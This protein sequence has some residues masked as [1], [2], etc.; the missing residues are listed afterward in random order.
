MM[1][2]A[3]AVTNGPAREPVRP[4]AQPPKPAVL[5][6]ETAQAEEAK[7]NAEAEPAQ[8]HAALAEVNQTMQMASIGVRF[9]FDKEADTMIAKVVDVETGVVIRQM[10]SAEVVRIA[11]VLGKLQ[12]LLVSQQV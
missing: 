2:P 1:I 6:Q 9:E 7:K 5:V 11:K 10:P 8:A 3:S 4:V 12:G